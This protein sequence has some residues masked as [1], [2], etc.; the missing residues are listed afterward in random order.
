MPIA[1]IP[2][3]PNQESGMD[4]LSGAQPV[5][6]NVV[7]DGRGAVSRRPGVESHDLGPIPSNTDPVVGLFDLSNGDVFA[8]TSDLPGDMKLWKLVAGNAVEV[9][10]PSKTL[11]AQ[12]RPTWVETEALVVLA[13]GRAIH[14]IERSGLDLDYLSNNAPVGSHVVGHGSRILANDVRADKGKISYSAPAQGTTSYAG[15][16]QWTSTVTALGRSGFFSAEARP[17]PVVALAETA[18]EIYAFGSTNVQTFAPDASFVY[19]S[20]STRE[21]GC[22]AP[23]SVIRDD[24]SFAWLDDQRRFISSDGRNVTIL[25]S[26]IKK[27]LDDLSRVDDCFGYR[28]HHGPVDALCWCFPT[29]GRTFVYQRGGG[30]AT[31]MGYDDAADAFVRFIVNAHAL[32]RSDNIVGTTGGSIGRLRHGVD[33]D[34]G[35]RVP[36]WITT[37]HQNRQTDAR[38]HSKV[39]RF[40]F[41]RGTEATDPIV[42]LSWRDDEGAWISPVEI[43]L[44]SAPDTDPVV[45]LRS[46]GA[47][48]R[49]DWRITFHGT[50]TFALISATE[51]YEV[52]EQ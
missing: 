23:Y 41:R 25:S 11:T 15:H 30:W 49:R 48:R 39:A 17:D 34:L 18:N 44:G 14:R 50:G 46:L 7:V 5:A 3:A 51:E 38:K 29:D 12:S 24:Q 1:A 20:V 47:Y 52:T 16:Q 28:V 45:E 26:A 13:T 22:V 6:I 10:S 36:A 4:A 35:T 19:S 37:G 9:T 33:T 27:T 32:N 42:H 2:F 43:H 31:W 21:F 8:A 40:V